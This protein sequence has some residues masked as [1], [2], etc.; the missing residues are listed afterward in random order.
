[1]E[2]SPVIT[3][4][5]KIMNF[6]RSVYAQTARFDHAHALTEDELF[7]AAP[8]VF[9][10]EAHESRSARFSPIPTIEVLRGLQKEGFSVVG[11]KQSVTRDPG[12]APFTKHLLRLRKIEDDAKHSVGDTVFE[13]LLRNANDGTSTY[14]LFAGLFRIRCLNSLVALSETLSSVKVRHSGNV[15]DNVIEGSY[16]V[17]DEAELALSAPQD[18]SQLQLTQSDQKV[19]AEAV[20]TVRFG[21]TEEGERPAIDPAQLL[22]PRREGDRANDLWTAWNRT[23]ENAIRGNLHG[24][25]IDENNRRRRVTTR[26]IKGVDQT[27]RINKALWLIGEHFAAAKKAAA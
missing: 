3:L 5:G 27:L 7:R 4:K 25:R 9:A 13:M 11:A 19:L 2:L 22:I 8:S 16:R 14:E 26:E 10:T 1:L 20:H 21:E 15:A 18:W 17:L 6:S 12:R 23:Q 24:S